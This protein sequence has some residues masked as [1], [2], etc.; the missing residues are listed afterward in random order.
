MLENEIFAAYRMQSVKRLANLSKIN[1]F[2]GPNN[3][4]KSRFLRK[5]FI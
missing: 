4:G 2:G 5:I 1:L 3:S